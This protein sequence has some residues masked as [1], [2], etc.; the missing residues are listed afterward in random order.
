MQETLI[1]LMK[2]EIVAYPIHDCLLVKKL[3]QYEAIETYRNV[4]RSYVLRFNRFS[5]YNEID[6]TIPVSVEES[7]KDKV[8]IAG[9]Y[10]SGS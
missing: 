7:G 10:N 3:H 2:R 9:C 5:R 8:R 1:A 4:I 6:I